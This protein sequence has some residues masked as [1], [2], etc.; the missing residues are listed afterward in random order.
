MFNY[1]K[2]VSPTVQKV[3]NE[4]LAENGERD[5]ERDPERVND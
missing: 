1:F 4:K 5:P 3:L 2:L